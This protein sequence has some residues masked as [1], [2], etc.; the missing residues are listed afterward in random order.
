MTNALKQE[1]CKKNAVNSRRFFYIVH[2]AFCIALAL[3]VLL[4]FARLFQTGF[5]AFFFARVARQQ[6]CRAQLL[7]EILIGGDERT[8]QSELY[9]SRLTGR[10]TAHNFGGNGETTFILRRAQRFAE[11]L[12]PQQAREI[13]FDRALVHGKAAL[14]RVNAYACG[15]GFAASNAFVIFA[16]GCHVTLLPPK[17]W[18]AAPRAD[19]LPWYKFSVS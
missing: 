5:L 19:A 14:P 17:L 1:Y 3:G 2:C 11:H 6:V 8:R 12:H 15:R 16:C 7:F 4:G 18:A 13:F 10:T 9:G